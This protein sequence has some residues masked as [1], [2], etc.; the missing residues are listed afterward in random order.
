M[1]RRTTRRSPRGG[2]ARR[3]PAQELVA[4]RGEVLAHLRALDPDLD[5]PALFAQTLDVVRLAEERAGLADLGRWELDHVEQTLA[6]LDDGPG[7][8]I[9]EGSLGLLFSFLSATGRWTGSEEALERLSRTLTASMS[10]ALRET[11]VPHHDPAAESRAVQQHAA[12]GPLV[13][14]LRWFG[15]RP[16]QV[17][18]TGA[19]RVADTRALIDLLALPVQPRSVT[20]MWDHPDLVRIWQHALGTACIWVSGNRGVITPTGVAVLDD[21]PGA[22]AAVVALLFAQSLTRPQPLLFADGLPVGEVAE[23]ALAALAGEGPEVPVEMADDA[24]QFAPFEAAALD[25][26]VDMAAAGADA[27]HELGVLGIVLVCQTLL[28]TGLFSAA[29]GQLELVAG[30]ESLALTTLADLLDGHPVLDGATLLGA[31]RVREAVSGDLDDVAARDVRLTVTLEPVNR[32]VWRRV[33]LPAASSLADLHHLLRSAWEWDDEPWHEFTA[34]APTGATTCY[35]GLDRDHG[36]D[37]RRVTLAQV[38]GRAAALEYVV[39][40]GEELRATIALDSVV[41]L[42]PAGPQLVGGEGPAPRRSW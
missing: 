31:A 10:A 23:L 36:D 16:R 9:A 8:S 35:S 15:F 30:L 33:Q 27:E 37:E 19:L 21:K 40:L 1:S 24:E 4:L 6:A 11:A 20:S 13:E 17:T 26:L 22:R 41:A 29:T 25:V 42:N 14:F 38:L 5:A 2:A 18:A 34:V 3:R 7:P 39:D 28:S 12:V 32:T